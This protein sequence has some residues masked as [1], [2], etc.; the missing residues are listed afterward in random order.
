MPAASPRTSDARPS[1]CTAAPRTSTTPGQADWTAIAALKEHVNIPVLGNGDI[2]EAADALRMMEETGCDGVVVGRGCLGRPWLFR[3]LAAAFT[4]QPI[5]DP[6]HLGEVVSMVR[7]HG[8]LLAELMG[9]GRGMAD[10]RKHMAWYFKGF[11]V[12]GETRTALGKVATL[13]ELDTLLGCRSTPTS[14]SRRPS[15]ASRVGARGHRDG[16]CC[17]RGGWTTS[18]AT[19]WT[20]T[21]SSRSA[22]AEAV[23][24]AVGFPPY[25][26]ADSH[27]HSP[28]AVR[29]GPVESS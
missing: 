25:S 7:R 1:R 3:D 6:P 26:L 4:G 28:G 23:R 15:W 22:A 20:P 8:E 18:A 27:R 17:R 14:R 5:P 2:W 24:A 19:S 16:W 11:V 29:P 10:L 12:G 13:S 21:P 9:E